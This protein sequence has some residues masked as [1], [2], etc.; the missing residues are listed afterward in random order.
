[1]VNTYLQALR[2]A[3]KWQDAVNLKIGRGE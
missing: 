1:M 3:G 2:D